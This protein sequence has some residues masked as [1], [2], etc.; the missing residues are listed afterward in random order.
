MSWE[1]SDETPHPSGAPLEEG[2]PKNP[3]PVKGRGWGKGLRC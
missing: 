2:E 1:A 3:C